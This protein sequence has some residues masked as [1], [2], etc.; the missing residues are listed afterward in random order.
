[1][2]SM[3]NKKVS[4][5]VIKAFENYLVLYEDLN[6]ILQKDSVLDSIVLEVSEEMER[7]NINDS[8]IGI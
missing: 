8:V 5:E 4:D 7:A 6:N 3:Q 2:V 1:M